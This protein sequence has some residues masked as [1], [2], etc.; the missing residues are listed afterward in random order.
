MKSSAA[1]KSCSPSPTALKA[2]RKQEQAIAAVENPT[3]LQKV[4]RHAI[5]ALR[6]IE[7]DEETKVKS[8]QE[9]AEAFLQAS[10]GLSDH[11]AARTIE[12]GFQAG[13]A[14]PRQARGRYV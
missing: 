3:G 10:T 13:M 1:S 8:R 12:S 14:E 4:M 6:D 9:R 5:Q 11:E 2:I 7:F